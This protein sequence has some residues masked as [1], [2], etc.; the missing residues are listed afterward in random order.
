VGFG[1]PSL[2]E[3]SEKVDRSDGK[4][5]GRSTKGETSLEFPWMRPGPMNLNMFGG[6][7]RHLRRLWEQCHDVQQIFRPNMEDIEVVLKLDIGSNPEKV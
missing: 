2:E 3:I 6:T 7:C 5:D 1:R 4:S